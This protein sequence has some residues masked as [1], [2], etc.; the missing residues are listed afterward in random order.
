M[1]AVWPY[2]LPPDRSSHS[3]SCKHQATKS[4]VIMAVMQLSSTPQL[5]RNATRTTCQPAV[6]RS[7][8]PL[9]SRMIVRAEEQATGAAEPVQAPAQAPPPQ[10]KQKSSWEVSRAVHDLHRSLPTVHSSAACC[11]AVD[12]VCN[13]CDGA[14]AGDVHLADA[15][16]CIVLLPNVSSDV[17][18]CLPAAH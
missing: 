18:I 2:K 3:I 7:V 1:V 17:C 8:V 11:H 14:R 4:S 5:V 12:C 9:R 10:P 16:Q 13:S 15:N 6:R